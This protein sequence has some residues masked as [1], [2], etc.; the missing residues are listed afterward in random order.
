[1]T[2]LNEGEVSITLGDETHILRPTLNAMRKIS[3]A[4]GGFRLALQSWMNQD[5][6]AL[7]SI[8]KI[9]ADIPDK[10]ETA[11]ALKVY[12]TGMNDRVLMPVYKYLQVLINGGKNPPPDDAPPAEQTAEATEGNA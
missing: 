5:F 9:G 3:R 1:M 12:E 7:V 6:D 8:I 4:H 10:G 11:L 2:D